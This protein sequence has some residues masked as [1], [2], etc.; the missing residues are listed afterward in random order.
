M[1][2]YSP[3]ARSVELL[4]SMEGSRYVPGPGHFIASA[5][6]SLV[7][8]HDGSF[9]ESHDAAN[10]TLSVTLPDPVGRR[11]DEWI[12]GWES[13]SDRSQQMLRLLKSGGPILPE[14]F[15]LGG[16]LEEE[17]ERCLL[18][19]LSVAPATTLAH[20]LEFQAP[21][22]KGSSSERLAKALGQIRK[23]KPKKEICKP[24]YAAEIFW[25]FR[26]DA[27]HRAAVG[28]GA[29]DQ[30]SVTELCTLLWSTPPDMPAI[31]KILTRVQGDP[32]RIPRV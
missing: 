10:A 19:R 3:K 5:R 2:D 21:A 7:E 11:L 12:P 31:L 15:L 13:F 24:A 9:D 4:F 14:D 18:A 1:L 20:D 23:G 8:I 16:I 27:R 30:G 25:A 22:P 32:D 28:I 29:L 17:L 26:I 6:R